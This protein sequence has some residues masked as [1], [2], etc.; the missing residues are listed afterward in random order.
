MNSTEG[1]AIVTCLIFIALAF[2]AVVLAHQWV[3]GKLAP[4]FDALTALG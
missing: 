3:L 4:V 2:G 1:N